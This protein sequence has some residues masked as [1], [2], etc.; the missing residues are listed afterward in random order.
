MFPFKPSS[1]VWNVGK[2][3]AFVLEEPALSL[4]RIYF[5]TLY[6]RFVENVV[7]EILNKIVAKKKIHY[8][9]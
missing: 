3:L 1:V 9:Q 4:A 5:Q 7:K 6:S 2:R 8:L